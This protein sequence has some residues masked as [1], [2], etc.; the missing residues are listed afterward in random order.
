MN[1]TPA[2]ILTGS[3]LVNDFHSQ[4]AGL[5]RLTPE[6]STL[7]M[8]DT[9]YLLTLRD[10]AYFANGVL[11]ETGLA[12]GRFYDRSLPLG[13]QPYV[14]TPDIVQGSYF[15]TSHSSS[16]RLQ[17]TADLVIPPVRRGGRHEFKVGTDIDRI[18]YDQS[19]E[20]QPFS[21][22]REDGTLAR[23]VTFPTNNVAFARSNAELTGYAQD[24]W[25][26]SDRLLVETGVRLDW[27]QIVRGVLA[28]PRLASSYMLTHG[29]NTKLVAGVGTYYDA[30]DLEI[31]S[32]PQAGERIDFFYNKTGQKLLGPTVVTSFH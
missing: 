1:L 7:N 19:F 31:I 18:S 27:D 15:E 22:V 21:I 16:D 4:H 30:S 10:L 14:I 5:S 6:E 9:A 23:R 29:G 12:W 26:P 2:N 3:F 20:R 17:L 32:Q 25:S 11:L 13:D 8:T 24:R 28:S